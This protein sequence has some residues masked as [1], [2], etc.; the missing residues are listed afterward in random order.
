MVE[1]VMDVVKIAGRNFLGLNEM[2]INHLQDAHDAD[3]LQREEAARQRRSG[4]SGGDELYTDSEA[5]LETYDGGEGQVEE[6][7]AAG[8][9]VGVQQAMEIDRGVDEEERALQQEEQAMSG[10]AQPIVQLMS[11]SNESM[12]PISRMTSTS[13]RSV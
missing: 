11:P 4:V 1:H 2:Q 10:D 8:G 6:V 12:P 13:P 5:M 9:G 7:E 3:V